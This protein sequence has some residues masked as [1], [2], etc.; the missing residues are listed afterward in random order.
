MPR[1]R[2][3]ASAKQDLRSVFTGAMLR[4]IAGIRDFGEV[5]LAKVQ[6]QTDPDGPVSNT[7]GGAD[8]WMH[9]TDVMGGGP[10]LAR[11][12]IPGNI[13]FAMP[14]AGD[15]CMV[16]RGRDAHAPGTPYVLH[17]D[18][19][20]ASRMPPWMTASPSKDG[21]YT[22][23]GLRLE[24]SGADV[25]V[26]PPSGHKVYVGAASGGGTQ[27]ATLGTD[28]QSVLDD[29]AS[30]IATLETYVEALAAALASAS[31]PFTPPTPVHV[32]APNTK[33]AHVE[34]L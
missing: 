11:L 26:V 14:N 22:P 15:S 16:L 4:A 1:V 2:R 18:A 33:A 5:I 27:P 8:V 23:R 12:F 32:T 10:G 17:G 7:D 28:N 25:E 9:Y 30:R 34:V 21:L 13:L 19:G 31:I 29:H 20:D 6:N 24:S 3:T